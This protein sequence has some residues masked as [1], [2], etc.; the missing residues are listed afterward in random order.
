MIPDLFFRKLSALLLICICALVRAHPTQSNDGFIEYPTT[1]TSTDF[2]ES[3]LAASGL[4][5]G[6]ATAVCVGAL[7]GAGLLPVV[8]VVGI[9]ACL[10]WRQ[11]GTSEKIEADRE[12]HGKNLEYDTV[13]PKA[14]LCAKGRMIY[15]LDGQDTVIEAGG[16]ERSVN[17]ELDAS[18]R[19]GNDA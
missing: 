18:K 4:S 19:A 16:T 14:E 15:E 5:V 8:I 12:M 3:T 11:P 2:S 13:Y 7:V 6:A 1:Y 17:V 9:G 10:E